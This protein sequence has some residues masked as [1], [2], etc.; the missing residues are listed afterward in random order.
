[1]CL[2]LDEFVKLDQPECL[3]MSNILHIVHIF[4][5]TEVYNIFYFWSLYVYFSLS[6]WCQKKKKI[7]ALAVLLNGKSILKY[8]GTQQTHG[9][10]VSLTDR[11]SGLFSSKE[12]KKLNSV[13]S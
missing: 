5:D 13:V 4:L 2:F 11:F 1:M 6:Y 7:N 8:A 12:I 10:R 3:Y 9:A